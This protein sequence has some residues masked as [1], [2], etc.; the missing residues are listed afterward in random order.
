MPR[1]AQSVLL[2]LPLLFMLT[3][4][5]KAAQEN[6]N[7]LPL[8]LAAPEQKEVQ[9]PELKW[10]RGGCYA[11]WCETGWYSS[12]AAAD[13]DG[14]GRVEVIASAYSIVALDRRTG[15]LIWRVASGH[16]RA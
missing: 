15:A 2:L 3:A 10:Q 7:Y 13:L 1:T 5:G 12:P 9:A 8:V 11:S 16:D 14:D 4:R 6:R